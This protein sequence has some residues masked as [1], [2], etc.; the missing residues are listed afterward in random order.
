M[1]PE[2]CI[3]ILPGGLQV[4]TFIESFIGNLFKKGKLSDLW[5]YN[6]NLTYFGFYKLFIKY[7]DE[8]I[9]PALKLLYNRDMEFCMGNTTNLKKV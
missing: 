5:D 1:L 2:L 7:I 3:W 8:E 9:L 4:T 6:Y